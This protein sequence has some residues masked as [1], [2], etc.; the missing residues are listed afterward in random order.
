[1]TTAADAVKSSVDSIDRV[2]I[3]HTGRCVDDSAAILRRTADLL[4]TVLLMH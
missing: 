3:I 2:Q 1:M 4:S